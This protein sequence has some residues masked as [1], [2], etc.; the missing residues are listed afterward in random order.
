MLSC[1]VRLLAN[2]QLA[3]P[4]R[5][6]R[7]RAPARCLAALVEEVGTNDFPEASVIRQGMWGTAVHADADEGRAAS[8][9]TTS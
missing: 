3:S 7:P 6:M 8:P 5:C 1:K 9:A 2:V 4:L